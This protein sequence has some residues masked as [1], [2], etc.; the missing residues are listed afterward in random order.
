[1]ASEPQIQ[2]STVRRLLEHTRR[3]GE[4][5]TPEQMQALLKEHRSVVKKAAASIA[6]AVS[7]DEEPDHAEIKESISDLA[8]Y[9]AEQTYDSTGKGPKELA[10]DVSRDG[11]F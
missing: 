7:T 1:M 6:W 3:T 10:A 9:V 4:L 5:P 11:W 8:D 2:A